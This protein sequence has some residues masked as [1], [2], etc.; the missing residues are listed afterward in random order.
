MLACARR[1]TVSAKRRATLFSVSD[2]ARVTSMTSYGRGI[3][4]YAEAPRRTS[5]P[6]TMEM[7]SKCLH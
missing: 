2:C 5:P 6:S 3:Y 1:D 4:V 7:Y